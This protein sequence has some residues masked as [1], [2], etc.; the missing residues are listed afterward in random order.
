MIFV[1][2][3]LDLHLKLSL[4]VIFIADHSAIISMKVW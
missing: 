1:N 2:G 4:Y 3:D